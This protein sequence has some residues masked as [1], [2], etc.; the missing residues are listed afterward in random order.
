[1]ISL[2]PSRDQI[3]WTILATASALIA[4]MAIRN[5]I[6]LGWRITTHEDPP[7]N[8]ADSDTTWTQAIIWTSL[9][10]LAVG[11]ARLF[12]RRSVA[13]GWTQYYGRKPPGF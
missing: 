12:A 10:G 13:S 7:N 6:H 8:P 5:V 9:S 1:M 4:G 2:H 11:F 3:R